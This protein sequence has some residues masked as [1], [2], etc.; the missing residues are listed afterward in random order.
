MSRICRSLL[1]SAPTITCVLCPAGANR[2]A[3]FSFAASMPRRSLPIER[4]MLEASFS[5]A[6]AASDVAVGSST[7]IESRSA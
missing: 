2:G 5:G 7:L 6:S 1:A 3:R 4:R